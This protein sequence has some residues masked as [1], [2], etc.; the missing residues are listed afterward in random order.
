MAMEIC[1]ALVS[2]KPGLHSGP[3]EMIC[4]GTPGLK[5]LGK[6]QWIFIVYFQ[7]C[8]VCLTLRWGGVGLFKTPGK[9]GTRV[10]LCKKEPVG[11]K[12]SKMILG[13]INCFFQGLATVGKKMLCQALTPQRVQSRGQGSGQKGKEPSWAPGS[14]VP[15]GNQQEVGEEPH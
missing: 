10:D 9:A 8:R 14:E 15:S 1:S 12:D 4:A 6:P 7:H 13:I 11:F 2:E 5:W 3:H